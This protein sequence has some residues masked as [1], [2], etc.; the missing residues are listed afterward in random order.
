MSALLIEQA[1][2]TPAPTR[3][4]WRHVPQTRGPVARPSHPSAPGGRPTVTA[5]PLVRAAA[6]IAVT[7][8]GWTLTRRGLIMVMALFLT[9]VAAATVTLIGA[10]LAVPDVPAPPASSTSIG[11]VA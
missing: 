11:A 6:P 2:V 3:P 8:A 5:A 10:F 9:V 1:P 4:R 7:S